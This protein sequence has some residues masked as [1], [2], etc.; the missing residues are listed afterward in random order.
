MVIRGAEPVVVD[1]GASIHRDVW[2]DQVFSLVEP[3]DIRWI[4]ISHEEVDHFGNARELLDRCPRA[5]LVSCFFLGERIAAEEP[6][7]LHRLRWVEPGQHLHVGDRTLAIVRPPL[8]DAPTTRGL[9]DPDTGVLWAVDCFA[10]PTPG[11]V[12]YA[13]DLPPDR[14]AEG[15]HLFN[16]LL[17]PWH[18]LVDPTRFAAHATTIADMPRA[19]RSCAPSAAVNTT[20]TNRLPKEVTT[21]NPNPRIRAIA[22]GAG[23]IIALAVSSIA[24]AAAL[25][26]DPTSTPIPVEP[27]NGIGDTPMPVEPDNGIGDTPTSEQPTALPVAEGSG[28]T[29]G[30]G[31]L[32]DGTWFG[33]VHEV[34]ASEVQFDLACLFFGDDAVKA[35]AEDGAESPPPNDYYIRNN[36]EVRTLHVP[37]DTEVTW[38]RSIGDPVSETSTSYAEWI[39][40]D[41]DG[42]APGIWIIVR[43]GVVV[44]IAE[45]W[46]P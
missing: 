14:C 42:A 41:R 16:S 4:F 19:P 34:D 20:S 21:M 3:G 38:Y 12:G 22:V 1:T 36:S 15:F 37:A 45:Y 33:F 23:L 7:P 32:G 31:H 24:V 17:A 29:P 9:Y 46:T 2:F 40:A 13:K 44:A 25:D 5:T 39:R 35:S 28:C 18:S 8:F 10:A 30:P 26:D 11:A 43:N 27:D 6:L